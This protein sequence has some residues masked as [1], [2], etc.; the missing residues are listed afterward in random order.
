MRCTVAETHLERARGRTVPVRRDRRTTAARPGPRQLRAAPADQLAAGA[1]L[2]GHRARRPRAGAGVRHGE[3]DVDGDLYDAARRAWPSSAST[4]SRAPTRSGSPARCSARMLAAAATS[5]RPTAEVPAARAGAGTPRP[6][7]AKAI[8][9]HYDVSNRFYEW[10]LGPSM[11]YTCAV[12]PTRDATLEEAQVASSTW[13]PASSALEPG[14]RL[15]D[16]GLRLGR[17]GHARRRG[18]TAC[19]R[20]ASRCR[21]SRPSGRR[22]RS[23]TPG[24]SDLAEVR[25]C[26]Y[27][28]VPER[29]FDAISS[30]GLTEHIGKA[31]LPAYFASLHTPAAA[32]RPAAQPLHHPAAHARQAPRSTAFIDRY[33]FP[34]G[35]LEPV[36]LIVAEMHDAGLR[37]AP[38]GEPARAL[39]ADA[40]RLGRATWRSTG[41]RRSP[42][43]GSARARVWRL[44]MAGLRAGLRA[45]QHPAAPGARGAVDRARR[46][47]LPVARVALTPREWKTSL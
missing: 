24:S 30:I 19:R 34:D 43:S 13:S 44:Y 32:G 47:G 15:L 2:P 27:R 10:V 29:E 25:H 16:V 18:T 11:A 37:G 20:S 3:L 5:R 28:D 21:G 39:R 33:V 35:E 45:R 12:Y 1:R 36:G 7:D 17:H 46:L 9:H 42:R 40:A 38:R 22:R 4:I 6:R 31:N 8:S 23:P 26:D 41:T 14:M